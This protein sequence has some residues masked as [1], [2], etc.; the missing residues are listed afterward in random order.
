MWLS[1]GVKGI[2][3]ASL[4]ADIGHEI[5]T[6][7]LPSLLTS[8]LGAPAS[9]LG[10]IE[11]FSDALAGVARFGGGALADEPARRRNLAVGGYTATAVLSAAIAPATATWQVAILR[12]G[13]WTAR[14]LRVPARNALLADVVP[15]AAYG[16]AY[17]FERAMDNL[18]AILGPLA[19]IGLVATVGTRWAIALSII[20]GL[21]ATLAIIYAIRH[22]PQP[23][24]QP[25]RA[26]RFHIR[27]VLTGRLRSL[28]AGIGAFEFGN[29]AATLLIL[30][31]T[32]LLEPGHGNDSA[33][34]IAALEARRPRAVSGARIRASRRR[35]QGRRERRFEDGPDCARLRGIGAR[36]RTLASQASK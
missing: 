28:F 1:P 33:T 17:G 8:T 32:E 30:R 11:G 6:A 2:G 19:A 16:R 10:P 23:T 4:L 31:A 18:G 21:M 3:S 12:A 35:S 36:T 24:P 5:P 15:A 13:A 25:K 9:A 20:P 22:T 7:L 26:L 27:P 34:T 14:G 29:C